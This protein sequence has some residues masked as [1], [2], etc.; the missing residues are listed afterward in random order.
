MIYFDNAT[1]S[2]PKPEVVYEAVTNFFRNIGVSP[3]RSSHQLAQAANTIV[4][5]TRKKLATLFGVS[6]PELVIFTSGATMALN[7]CLKG[8]LQPGDHVITSTWE[9][10]SVNRP[11]RTLEKIDSKETGVSVTRVNINVNR[12]FDLSLIANA[13][14]PNTRLV[15]L[16][17]ASNVTGAILP[18]REIGEFTNARN[19]LLLVDAAQSAGIVPINMMEM[20]V[21]ILIFAGHKGLLGPPGIGGV[22]LREDL[23][24]RSTIEGGTGSKSKSFE[25]PILLPDR[26]EAGTP[27]TLGIVGLHASV[28][29]LLKRDISQLF[30]REIQLRTRFVKKLGKMDFLTIYSGAGTLEKLPIVSINMDRFRPGEL[31][32]ILDSKFQIMSRSGFHC[33]PAIH[34]QLG[35]FSKGG[36]VR[37]SLNHFNTEE[38]IDTVVQALTAIKAERL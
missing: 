17:H 36:A 26:L 19:I 12:Q 8:L 34:R 9:H 20:Q 33:A 23:P 21:D 30:N 37:F 3:G 2:K 11:L 35:T 24:I 31:A 29:Y 13:V 10:N 15:A 25:H 38:E 32:G 27:N 6:Y 28:D 4:W 16:T 22:C 7:M 18:I 14:Q 1:T 5:E